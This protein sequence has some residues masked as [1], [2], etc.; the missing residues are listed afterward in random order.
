MFF[1]S[2][3]LIHFNLGLLRATDPDREGDRIVPAV[4][5][6]GE[7]PSGDLK[8]VRSVGSTP[9]APQQAQ[10]VVNQTLSFRDDAFRLSNLFPPCLC[11]CRLLPLERRPGPWMLPT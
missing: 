4:T 3:Q 8:P 5:A 9:A 10:P 6:R 1:F 7:R 11:L 2:Y